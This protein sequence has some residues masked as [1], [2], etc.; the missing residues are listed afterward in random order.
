IPVTQE[1]LHDYREGWMIWGILAFDA[2]PRMLSSG[3]LPILQ[4]AS[5][6]RESVTPAGI[7][8]GAIT[9]LTAHMQ[10]PLVRL[11]YC[12]PPVASRIKDIEAKYYVALRLSVY[13]NLGTTIAANPSTIL[14]IA[15]LGDREKETLIRDLANGTIDPK[16]D[17]TPELRDALR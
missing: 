11:T 13:R 16:W 2:H 7:P 9:G 5:D 15:R 1:S 10:N 14:A 6:W 17:L 12:M 3:M 4:I 8:C